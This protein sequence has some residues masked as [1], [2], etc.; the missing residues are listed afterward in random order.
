VVGFARRT[1]RFGG[2]LIFGAAVGT[3]V[4]VLLAPKSGEEL[5]AELTD[6]IEEAKRAGEEAELLET[7]RLKRLFRVAVND[8]DAFTGKYDDRHREKSPEEEAAERLKKEQEEA[9][10][11]RRDERKATQ[12]VAK[13]QERARKAEEEARKAH[14]KAQKEEADVAKAYSEAVDKSAQG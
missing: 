11:A 10:K 12:E 14:E 1:L 13:A 4:S 9:A 3:A 8:P 7:E 2:G 5:K 6:R